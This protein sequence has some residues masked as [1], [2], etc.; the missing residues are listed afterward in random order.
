MLSAIVYGDPDNLGDDGI[1]G[2]LGHELSH[3]LDRRRGRHRVTQPQSG[4]AITLENVRVT[5]TRSS[6]RG[7]SM[8]EAYIPDG[9]T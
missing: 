4:Q 7:R 1:E 6:A 5:I 3:A 2:V 9:G 8:K